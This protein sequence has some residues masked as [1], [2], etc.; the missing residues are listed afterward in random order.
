MTFNIQSGAHGLERVAEVIRKGDPD[1][2]AL[3]EVERGT[4][5]SAGADQAEALAQLTGLTHHAHFRAAN[6]HGGEYGLAV[7]SRFPI[8]EARRLSLPTPRGHE[9]RAVARAVLD[10]EGTE[11]SVY[12]THLSHL[13]QR[14][15]LRVEQARSIT[16]LVRADRRPALLMGDLND[17]PDSA[18]VLSLRRLLPCVFQ[19][20]GEGN[21]GT[22][23]LPF[24]LADL[25][26]DY[27][28]AS[29]SFVPRRAF[30]MRERASDHFPLVADL[31]LLPGRPPLATLTP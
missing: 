17:A 22:Y 23:P 3:Q 9:T 16:R 19:R 31:E 20:V 6:L 1:V 25:R 8:V 24:P 12:V 30:V 27:V 28:L 5:R 10:V 29:E 18:A 14:S 2:V 4:R 15:A 21:P 11:V 7:L 13:P 26:L